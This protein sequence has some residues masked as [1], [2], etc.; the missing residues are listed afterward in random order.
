MSVFTPRNVER[1]RAIIA[2]YPEPKSALLPLF[3]LVQDQDGWVSDE[4]IAEIAGMVGC[5]PAEAQGTMSFYTMYKRHPVGRFLV[6]VCTCPVSMVHGA[7]E[8]LHGLE[9]RYADDPDVT[10]EEVECNA[11]CD[12]V[13]NMQVNYEYHE[14]L[15][16]AS[17]IEIIEEYKSG[18]RVARGISG[19][20]MEAGETNA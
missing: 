5:T 19:G 15:T 12:K 10:V 9:A 1:A 20:R 6:S 16:L 8:I 3:H 18:A 11:A 13:P 4:S 14:N 17:A 2:Q 7:Y